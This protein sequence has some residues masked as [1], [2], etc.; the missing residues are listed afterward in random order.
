MHRLNSS[1]L[2]LGALLKKSYFTLVPQEGKGKIKYMYDYRCAKF[3][4]LFTLWYLW[5]HCMLN[6]VTSIDASV[7]RKRCMA[8]L[9]DDV[10]TTLI[11]GLK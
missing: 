2:L 8:A 4:M 6:L 11:M 10:R 3:T 1:F 7:K 9:N 5:T